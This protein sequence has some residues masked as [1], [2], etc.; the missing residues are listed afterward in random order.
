M[1]GTRGEKMG[2]EGG[3]TRKNRISCYGVTERGR[4]VTHSVPKLPV[5][6]PTA[7][8]QAVRFILRSSAPILTFAFRIGHYLYC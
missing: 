3:T 8:L 4:A 5:L 2:M 7:C 6:L 1:G